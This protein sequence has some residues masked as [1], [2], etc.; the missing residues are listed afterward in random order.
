MVV[1]ACGLL[2]S[3]SPVT[4]PAQQSRSTPARAA[5]VALGLTPPAIAAPTRALGQQQPPVLPGTERRVVRLRSGGWLR[6]YVDVAPLAP[7]R[8]LP[9]V[10][11]LHGR[12]QTPWRA[13]RVEG[14]D[15]YA[16]AGQA[17]VAY[18]AGYGGSWNAGRCCRPAAAAGVEDVSFVLRVLRLEERRH[19]VDRRRVFLVGFSNGGML[20]YRFACAHAAA[21]SAFA[22]VAGSLET[23]GCRP[24]RPLSLIDV[25][26][27]RDR[28]VP[29]AGTPFSP[30]AGAP[31]SS[32]AQSLRPWQ[33]AARGA[34]VVRLVR[35]SG[36]GHEWPTLRRG[37][38]DATAELWHFLL[39]H[40]AP[41]S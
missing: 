32:T 24:V 34:A 7:T 10:I 14:W 1:A 4:D 19:V 41:T 29:A 16:A 31:I 8:A 18:G 3:L 2:W 30:V 23:A 9:L 33:R 11:V 27:Q 25:Q 38:W 37:H 17:V 40:P 6:E 12:R 5:E 20:A 35:L 21:I 15:R 36:L 39:T 22:V 26:G 13:E 28:V